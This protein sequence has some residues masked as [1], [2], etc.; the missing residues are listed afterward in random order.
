[1]NHKSSGSRGGSRPGAG[2]PAGSKDPQTLAKEAGRE[3]ARTI[4]LAD[5]RPL[6]LAQLAKAKGFSYLVRRD[7][8]S[9][10][11]VPVRKRDLKKFAHDLIEVWETRPDTSAFVALMDRALD[12]AAMPVD[13][14]VKQQ[15]VEQMS[16]DEL[17]AEVQS[18][19]DKLK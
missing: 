4:I 11:F 17:V 1:M 16:T 7:I 15:P 10:K 12:R 18:I 9:G 8:A 19:L 2:R 14:T 13:L 5:L 6:L 3:L